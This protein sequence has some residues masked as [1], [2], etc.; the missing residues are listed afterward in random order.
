MFTERES[1]D[2]ILFMSKVVKGKRIKDSINDGDE[3][4]LKIGDETILVRD[5]VATGAGSFN[6]TV[7]GFEPSHSIEFRGLKLQ[8]SVDFLE[9]H[10]ISCYGA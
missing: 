10:V 4:T 5:A 6:G 1:T 2:G 8:Q 3:V 7:F 9:R